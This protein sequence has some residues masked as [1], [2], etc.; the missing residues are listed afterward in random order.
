MP[1]NQRGDGGGPQQRRVP[2]QDEQITVGQVELVVGESREADT[3]G[4]AGPSLH[5]LL[6]EL[7]QQVG[8]LLLELLG[9]PLG[10][11]AH[12]DDRPAHGAV[13]EGVEHVQEHG[14][15]AQQVQGLRAVGPHAGPFA[16]GQHDGGEGT[17]AH[18]SFLAPTAR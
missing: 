18:P 2:R 7:E 16:G 15:P 8:L 11:V 9:H 17:I 1:F 6:D 5:V 3:H 10:A 4:I 14:P 12:D 13:T